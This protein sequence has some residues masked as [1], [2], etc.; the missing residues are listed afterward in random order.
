MIKNHHL[1]DLLLKG[2]KYRE[3]ERIRWDKVSASI[4]QG[5]HEC[6]KTWARTEHVD[7]KVLNEWSTLLI[8][9]VRKKIAKIEEKQKQK[10]FSNPIV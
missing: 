4:T 7:S 9:K 6:Q 1:K 10:H 2:P 3:K 8:D 5:I